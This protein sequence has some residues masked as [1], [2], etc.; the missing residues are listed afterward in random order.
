PD[1]GLVSVDLPHAFPSTL[2]PETLSEV[3]SIDV[4]VA[5]AR[6]TVW[7][8]VPSAIRGGAEKL[9]QIAIDGS[10]DW[11]QEWDAIVRRLYSDCR[12]VTLTPLHGGYNSKTFRVVAH[13]RDGRRT[14]PTVLKI[15]PI[16]MTAREERANREYVARF[17]LN[18]RTR[19]LG[20]ADEG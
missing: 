1:P 3:V 4:A 12:T 19:C 16:E 13:D 6:A 10:V 8:F 7:L 11:L 2:N 20:G 15:G 5:L 17:T 9:L 14:L 18:N